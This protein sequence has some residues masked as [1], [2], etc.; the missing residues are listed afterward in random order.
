V[1]F[2]Q[3]EHFVAVAEQG[4]FTAAS[5]VTSIVQSAL[6]TSIRNLETELGAVL[7]ERTT[8]R[9]ALSEAGRALLPR[10]RRVIAE[11]G[12][13][14][15]A[16]HAV[17]GLRQGRVAIGMIQWL[18][19]V[20]LPS[21]LAE[22]H[23]GHPGIQISVWNAPVDELITRL[24]QGGLDLAYLASDRPLPADLAG[25]RVY[26][27]NLVLITPP[28]HP[29]AGRDAV[30]WREL[31]E[32]PF[33]EF[34][35]GS[36]VNSIVRRVFAELGLRRRVVGQVTQID[37]QLA[38]VRT[39]IG[40]SVVQETMARA[41]ADRLGISA[42]TEPAAAWDVSLVARAPGPSNPAAAALLEH[43]TGPSRSRPAPH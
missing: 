27:E 17:A 42:L 1:E 39:G 9:V 38:L 22:F 23:R 26:A 12:A 40:V 20:D 8:R 32:L 33:V 31:D 35:E 21:E 6:S 16:V 37:L 18:G 10:A 25:R 3:L 5:R 19:A 4:S 29:L 41:H 7:F 11:A 43:L 34:S 24:R 36:A 13:A 15:D 30:A 2:R 14:V 28:G